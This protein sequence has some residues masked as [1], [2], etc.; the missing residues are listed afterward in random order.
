MSRMSTSFPACAIALTISA[1]CFP[2]PASAQKKP[3]NPDDVALPAPGVSAS[4]KWAPGGDRF[5]ISNGGILALYDVKAGK[6]R[7]VVSLGKLDS[8]A[9]Q[10]VIAETTD[11]TNRRVSERDIQWFADNRR[12]LVLASGDI[13]IVNTDNGGFDVL[14]HT[15]DNERDPKLSPDNKY[16]SF[17]R[18]HDLYVVEIATKNVIRLTSDGSDTLLNGELDWVYPEELDLN[19]AHWWAPDSRSIAYLQFDVS[20]GADFSAGL[21]SEFARSAGT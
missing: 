15:I 2:L 4:M 10:T 11:W 19:T 8:A 20:R 18:G 5:V 21:S 17:R 1:V 14:I 3:V 12:L 9:V 7:D 13:F 16:V 6:E